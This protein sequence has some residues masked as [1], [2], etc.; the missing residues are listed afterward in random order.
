MKFRRMQQIPDRGTLEDLLPEDLYRLFAETRL[1][2]AP[3][4]D[5]LGRL[6]PSFAARELFDSAA[7][8]AGLLRG[9]RTIK[10]AIDKMARKHGLKKVTAVTSESVRDSN[11]FDSMEDMAVGTEVACLQAGL[12]GLDARLEGFTR[13]AAAWAEG[14]LVSL[15]AHANDPATEVCNPW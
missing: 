9:S 4:R 2:H 7:G 6:R 14:D 8:A 12:Q 5:D 3:K 15:R 13:L 1:V 11:L 10:S